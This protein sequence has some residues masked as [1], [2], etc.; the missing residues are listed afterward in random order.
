MREYVS[1]QKK[2]KL[3]VE[4]AS[5]EMRS[6]VLGETEKLEAD[7]K[8][9]DPSEVINVYKAFFKDLGLNEDAFKKLDYED[10]LDFIGFV[11]NPKSKGPQT[12]P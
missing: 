11:L 1:K 9:A 6:P 5:Y 8:A 4:G 10:F 2:I 12:T 3:T 7:I